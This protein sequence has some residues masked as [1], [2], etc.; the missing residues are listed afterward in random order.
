MTAKKIIVL[1][2]LIGFVGMAGCIF[3]PREAEDPDPDDG[4]T[5]I[6]PGQPK[7]VLANLKSGLAAAANSN[8]ERSLHENITFIPRP[9]DRSNL[10]DEVFDGWNKEVEMAFLTRLKGIYLGE[11]L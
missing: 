2:L 9:E 5:W 11:R 1:M 10:G 7:D 3:E 4:G 8:Y 6:T